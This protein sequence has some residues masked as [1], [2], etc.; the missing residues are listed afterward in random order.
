MKII[1]VS[2]ETLF[3]TKSF[4]DVDYRKVKFTGV[5]VKKVDFESHNQVVPGSSPGGPT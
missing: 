5:K 2:F 1:S 4:A 3:F